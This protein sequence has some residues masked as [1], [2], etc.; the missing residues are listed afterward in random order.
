MMSQSCAKEDYNILDA[1]KENNNGY[2]KKARTKMTSTGQ[3]QG[4]VKDDNNVDEP[5]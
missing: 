5:Q 1:T 3:R 4:H 2:V